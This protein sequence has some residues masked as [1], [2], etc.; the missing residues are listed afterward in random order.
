MTK[1]AD[2]FPNHPIADECRRILSLDLD[3]TDI[4]TAVQV[5]TAEMQADQDEWIK[6]WFCLSS[7]ERSTW[8][9]FVD[10]DQWLAKEKAR[11]SN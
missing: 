10:Y 4:A 8:K 9:R 6:G 2:M 5:Y 3:E 1:V 7:V 11:V